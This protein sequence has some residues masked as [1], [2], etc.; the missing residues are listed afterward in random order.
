KHF[1]TFPNI[2]DGNPARANIKQALANELTDAFGKPFEVV[3][4]VF[5]ALGFNSL[6]HSLRALS[7]LRRSSLRTASTAAKPC[8]ADSSKLYLITGSI[9]TDQQGTM[10]LT[11][12]F[13][14]SEQRRF[15]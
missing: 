10:V 11:T 8:Q 6:V 4:N 9:H 3:N 7:A 13:N 5:R 1:Q 2:E 12:L 14:E 15:R